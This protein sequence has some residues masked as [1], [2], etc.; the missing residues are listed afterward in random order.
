MFFLLL[1]AIYGSYLVR[2]FMLGPTS[3][4]RALR[5]LGIRAAIIVLTVV[6]IGPN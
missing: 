5:N 4:A 1:S 3:D 6:A 2:D